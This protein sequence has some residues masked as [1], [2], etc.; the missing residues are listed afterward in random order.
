MDKLRVVLVRP[1]YSRNVGMVAR[2][3]ANYGL[4]H[5]ILIE[6]QCE[7]NMDAHEGAAGGQ[8]P[9]Q[10]LWRHVNVAP[11]DRAARPLPGA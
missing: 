3:M 1:K 7:I 5:L 10:K 8:G 11:G 2:A 9:L 6:P 4:K